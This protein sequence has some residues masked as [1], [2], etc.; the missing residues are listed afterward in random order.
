MQVLLRDTK[1]SFWRRL[2]DAFEWAYS[3]AFHAVNNDPRIL[4]DQRSHKLLDERFYIV[5]GALEK[6]AR[7][8][9]LISSG[10]KIRVNNWNY[11]L[12]R[13]GGVCLLQSYV[14]TPADMA[15]AARFREQHAAVN[16]FLNAPQLPL[17]DIEPNIY[18]VSRINGILIHGP[19][20]KKFSDEDQRLGFLNLVIPDQTYSTW[21]INISVAELITRFELSEAGSELPQ[22]DIAR[23]RIKRP[24]TKRQES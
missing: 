1:L 7:E 12:V 24:A 20:G 19:M 18:E 23:P 8:G 6:A 16:N 5:E 4:T 11:T 10:Q 3:D 2:R 13:G 15:R 14:Q 17:G 22:R 9:G 21:G